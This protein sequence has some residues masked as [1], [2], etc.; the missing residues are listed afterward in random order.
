V[1]MQ[2][3]TA[4]AVNGTWA[5]SAAVRRCSRGDKLAGSLYR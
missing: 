1:D 3:G 5:L 2:T 4:E